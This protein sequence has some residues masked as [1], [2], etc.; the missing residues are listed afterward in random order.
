ME[1]QTYQRIW[2]RQ[3]ISCGWRG[4]KSLPYHWWKGYGFCE[5]KT[6]FF[7]LLLLISMPVF[8]QSPAPS[9]RDVILAM[10]REFW[11]DVSLGDVE[12]ISVIGREEDVSVIPASRDGESAEMM[13]MKDLPQLAG[14]RKEI[15]AAVQKAFTF[16]VSNLSPDEKSAE[17]TVAPVAFDLRDYTQHKAIYDSYLID[18][19][20]AEQAGQQLPSMEGV[21]SAI[22]VRGSVAQKRIDLKTAEMLHTQLTP[23]KFEKTDKGWRINLQKFFATLSQPFAP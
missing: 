22:M 7:V 23:L 4:S 5:M 18:S 9:D 20:T 11:I 6:L 12:K 3:W 8:G 21:A 17:V 2:M 10:A 15:R 1:K 16:S 19:Y 13:K 14:E